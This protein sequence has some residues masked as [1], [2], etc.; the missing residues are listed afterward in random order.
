MSD[1]PESRLADLGLSLP[2]A[3]TPVANYVPYVISGKQVIISGQLPMHKGAPQHIGK[4]GQKMDA[5]VG[6]A[7][8]ELCALNLL[9]QLKAAC[10]GDL[11]RVKRCVK[12]GIF[13]N[14]TDDFIDQPAVANGASD[15][16][17]A[18]FGEAGKH[19]RAAVGVNT[20]PL[21]VAVEVEGVFEL[22]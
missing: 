9:A 13:V 17:V 16:M 4:I 7:A 2:E 22:V 11:A 6:K 8:A 20:L 10:A 19:A 15:L 14:S 12:L 21:G 5:N 1:T 3:P 18:V